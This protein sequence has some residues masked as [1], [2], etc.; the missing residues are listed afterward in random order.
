MELTDYIMPILRKAG[1]ERSFAGT[2]FCINGHL[3]TAGHVIQSPMTYYVRH[4]ENYMALDF[5]RWTPRQI[6]T[7]DKLGYDVA[8]YPSGLPCELTLS[9]T[10]PYKND[11]LEVLCWQFE[12]G[13]LR[14]VYTPCVVRGEAD[15]DGYFL[16]STTRRITHGA[17]GSPVYKDGRVYG[18]LA[19][20]RDFYQHTGPFA[21]IPPQSQRLMH[22]IE[23]NTC[24]VFKSTHIMRFI[25]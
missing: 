5:S 2:A 20:G 8:I 21:G 13:Q 4:G 16:I 19:M 7:D 9:G 3:L 22:R 17:S 12:D 15:E 1:D 18:I 23:E 25:P 6:L 14:Q 11:H 24:W 10:D